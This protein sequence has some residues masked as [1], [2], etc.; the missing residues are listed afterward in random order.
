MCCFP[1]KQVR[2]ARYTWSNLKKTKT[3]PRQGTMTEEDMI[4][5]QWDNQQHHQHIS[6]SYRET[7]Q[8]CLPVPRYHRAEA[9]HQSGQCRFF[10]NAAWEEHFCATDLPGRSEFF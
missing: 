1:T 10:A 3:L 6:S 5:G 9:S 7:D 4:K 8:A 2:Q